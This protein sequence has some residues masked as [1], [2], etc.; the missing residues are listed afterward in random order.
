MIKDTMEHFDPEHGEDFVLVPVS[1]YENYIRAYNV[2]ET[3][4][5]IIV[6]EW[7]NAAD[8]GYGGPSESM[9]TILRLYNPGAYRAC[10]EYQKT[11]QKEAEKKFKEKLEKET[12]NP[13]PIYPYNPY[14]ATDPGVLKKAIEITCESGEEK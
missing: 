3:V 13:G 2:A 6:D 12:L 11:A 5:D 9:K 8:N 1:G 7:K 4:M 14:P 10:V